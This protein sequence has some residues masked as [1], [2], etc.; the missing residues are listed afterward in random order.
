MALSAM[1]RLD[2]ISEVFSYLND[3][4]KHFFLEHRSHCSVLCKKRKEKE[5]SKL[6]YKPSYEL[7]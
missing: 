2:L 1:V 5:T 7:R 4:V 3:S 6:N